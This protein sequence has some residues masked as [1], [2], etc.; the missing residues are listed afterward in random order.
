MREGVDRF[1]ARQQ[2]WFV[3]SKGLLVKGRGDKPAAHKLP[4][5][6]DG[7]FVPDLLSAVERVRPTALIGVSGVGQAFTQEIIERMAALQERPIIFALSNPTSNAECTAEQAYQWTGGR[8]VFASGSPFDP[9]TFGG[10]TFHP[11][12]GNNVYIFPGVG[13]GVL[14]AGARIVPD[15]M[16]LE[17]ACTL[18]QEVGEEDL[19]CGRVY[20]SLK[21]IRRVSLEI[22]VAVAEEA[23]KLGIA[24]E[25]RPEDPKEFLRNQMFDPSYREYIP[26]A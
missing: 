17:A 25:P 3:D 26:G 10:K 4:F 9:V 15:S 19:A 14:G 2:C 22:A 21:E 5:T 11:G 16:F 13:L 20:P 6:H 18:A 7:E 1:E 23:W 8:V 24:L 12:Q